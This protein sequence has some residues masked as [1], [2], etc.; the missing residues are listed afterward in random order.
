MT[1]DWVTT[2]PILTDRTTA[3]GVTPMFTFG[4]ATAKSTPAALVG[5][6]TMRGGVLE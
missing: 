3:A 1:S 5:T 2:V 4:A 6:V